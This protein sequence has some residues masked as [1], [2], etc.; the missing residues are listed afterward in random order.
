M[1]TT[2]ENLKV[3]FAGE[4]QAFQKYEAFAKAAEKEGFANIAKLFRTTARAEQVHAEGHLKAMDAINTTLENLKV[5][6]GGETHEYEEMYPPELRDLVR[7][8]AG[9]GR[10]P[11]PLWSGTDD[12]SKSLT[13]QG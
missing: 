12:S 11:V 1:A 3:A 10:R 6:K 4:S 2:E 9:D 7:E 5:A 8:Q 13:G